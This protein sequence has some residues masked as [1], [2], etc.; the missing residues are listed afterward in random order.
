MV[1]PIKNSERGKSMIVIGSGQ[2]VLAYKDKILGFIAD[3][4]I[5]TIGINNMLGLCIP[6]YHLWT[7]RQRW[8]S[9]GHL[10]SN[11]ST[12]LVG[13]SITDD[14]VKKKF[15]GRYVRINHIDESGLPFSYE[16]EIFTGFFRTAGVFG[17]MVCHIMGASKIYVVGMDGYTLHSQDDLLNGKKSH[18]CYGQGYTDDADWSKCVKKDRMVDSALHN[19]RDYGVKFH[20]ITPTKFTDFY[21]STILGD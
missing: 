2:S 19:L 15:Q 10:S 5:S 4:N 11:A 17:I 21:D 7:N 6:K 20:I 18:H 13:K 14:S 9:F 8:G 16:N 3:N 1:K 12:L